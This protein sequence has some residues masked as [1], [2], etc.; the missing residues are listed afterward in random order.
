MVDPILSF[1]ACGLGEA[2]LRLIAGEVDRR[3]AG[4]FAGVLERRGGVMSLVLGPVLV[5]GSV[6]IGGA[7]TRRG[8][9][10]DMRFAEGRGTGVALGERAAVEE[11]LAMTR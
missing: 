1:F 8:M 5:V 11:V 9:E 4:D 3:D 2:K 6:V 7:E 10:V